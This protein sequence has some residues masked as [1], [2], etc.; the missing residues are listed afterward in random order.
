MWRQYTLA[1]DMPESVVKKAL[2]F[3]PDL[4][5]TVLALLLLPGL[6]ALGFWQLDR[7]EQKRHLKQLFEQRQNAPAVA[8]QQLDSQADLRYQPVFMR[9]HF[10]AE[11]NYLLDNKIYKGRVGYELISVFQPAASK[12]WLLINRGWIAG[13]P[14]RQKLPQI[15]PLSGTLELKGEVYVPL[16]KMMVLAET[17]E[18]GWPRVIQQLDMARISQQL[19]HPVFPYTIRLAEDQPGVKQRNWPVVNVQPEKHTGYAVQW[20]AMA[21]TVVFILILANSNL[22][23]LLRSS[24]NND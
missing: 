21:V 13:D 4:K 3:T 8:I 9:G 1:V 23:S 20:F 7:A 16:G 17:A 14:S 12:S 6:I 18:Q 22:W 2:R 10:I 15:A 11:K 19:Q 24:D 5:A